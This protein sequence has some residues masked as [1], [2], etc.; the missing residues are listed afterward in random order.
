MQGTIVFLKPLNG[1][2]AG[3]QRDHGI[4]DTLLGELS[5]AWRVW[6]PLPRLTLWSHRYSDC[7][8]IVHICDRL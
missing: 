2:L 4:A 8:A 1:P 3:Q 5:P 6:E 7:S